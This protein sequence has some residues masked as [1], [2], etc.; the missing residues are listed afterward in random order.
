MDIIPEI[1]LFRSKE[2]LKGKAIFTA[3]CG[4][5][6]PIELYYL[7]KGYPYKCREHGQTATYKML[8]LSPKGEV[9][10]FFGPVYFCQSCLPDINKIA[11]NEALYY[12]ILFYRKK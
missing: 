7:E 11:S 1:F 4:E 6:N 10:G 8:F 5:K 12:G 9:E 3:P 2:K